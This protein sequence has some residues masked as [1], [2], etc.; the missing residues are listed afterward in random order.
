M[1]EDRAMTLS[2]YSEH[3]IGRSSYARLSKAC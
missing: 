3:V 2:C 1:D